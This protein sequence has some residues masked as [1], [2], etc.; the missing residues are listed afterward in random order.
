MNVY[1]KHFSAILAALLLFNFTFDGRAMGLYVVDTT[2]IGMAQRAD[3]Y[4]NSYKYKEADELYNGYLINK[5]EKE[6]LSLENCYVSAD[7]EYLGRTLYNYAYN[8]FF[9]GLPEKGLYLLSLSC[10]CDNVWARQDYALLS[11]CES[12]IANIRLSDKIISQYR[13]I[14]E[15]HDCKFQ[16]N[17]VDEEKIA[18][19]FWESFL[20]S[21]N[22]IRELQIAMSRKKRPR[23]L[24][25]AMYEILAAQDNFSDQLK[26]KCKPYK[27]GTKEKDLI[28]MLGCNAYDLRELRIYPAAEVN[29]FATPYSQIY[30]T[31]GLVYRY[32]SMY[33]LLLG[34]CA[35]EMTHIKGHHSLVGLWK[36]YR[37]EQ[38]A[39]LAAGIAA[40]LYTASMSAASMYSASHGVANYN[41]YNNNIAINATN[42]YRAIE[43]SSFYFQ[44]KYSREQE[45][46]ADLIAYRFCEA[47]GLGGYAYIIA[48]QL[49]VE[50]DLYLKHDKTDYHPTLAYRI[51]FLKWL[52]QKEHFKSDNS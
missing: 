32:H 4:F 22:S 31:S 17:D 2:Y 3:K 42:L 51:T 37:K 5:L 10:K 15:N 21:N 12:A 41:S 18:G 48:L 9:M 52:Y 7:K 45:L 30:I 14:L 50:D 11:K 8:S 20:I 27:K 35:H 6:G 34:I 46:E 33:P 13:R 40:G 44:F 23:A 26:D 47:V 1:I 38:R 36:S 25:N 24:T 29:A 16:A 28:S 19:R 49:L 39:R 43:G